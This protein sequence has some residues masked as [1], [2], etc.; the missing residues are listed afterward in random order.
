MS[1]AASD[2]YR[3]GVLGGL[4]GL[5]VK[6]MVDGSVVEAG[7]TAAILGDPL[8]ALAAG[9]RLAARYGRPLTAG[10]LVLAGAA[11]AAVPLRAGTLVEAQV[12]GLGTV[13]FR[14]AEED[15]A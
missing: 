11:T 3:G 9:A 7:S 6:L 4:N 13:R 2:V 15:A 10:D 8:A 14:V 1:S 12:D 5:D